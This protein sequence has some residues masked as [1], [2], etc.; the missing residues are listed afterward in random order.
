MNERALGVSTIDSPTSNKAEAAFWS[1]NAAFMSL[2]T[3][4]GLFLLP[5]HDGQQE[6]P[7]LLK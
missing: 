1:A 3:L 5:S 6:P 4:E 2:L 7:L